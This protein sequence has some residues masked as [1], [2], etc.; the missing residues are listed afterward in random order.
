MYEKV[1][2]ILKDARAKKYGVASINVFNFETVKWVIQAAEE[3]KIPVLAMFYPGF[4]SHIPTDVM[5]DMIKTMAN[6]VKVPIGMHLDHCHSFDIAA[7]HMKYFDSIMI[8]GSAMPYEE[9][10]ALTKRIVEIARNMDIDVEAE[11]GHVGQGANIDDMSSAHFTNPQQAAE[12]CERTGCFSLA[13]AI[14]NAH[15]EYIATPNLD[16]EHF[17]KIRAAVDVPL[18]LHGGSDIPDE[19]FSES[20]QLG[21]SK[22]NL[23][24]QLNRDFAAAIAKNIA[25]KPYFLQAAG[26]CNEECVNLVRKRLQVLNPNNV[27]VI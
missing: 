10:V 9:N 16:F 21:M 5:T 25:A 6:K 11:L 19:Q 22:V 2:T 18:V 24:T 8:D 27:R 14:G 1:S 15:G 17:K 20:V 7:S 13:V 23:F 3:E 4:D 12:F 26:A